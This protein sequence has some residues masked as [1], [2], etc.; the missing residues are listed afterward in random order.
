[1]KSKFLFSWSLVLALILS[2]TMSMK[3]YAATKEGE[4]YLTS[5]IP[6]SLSGEKWKFGYLEGDKFKDYQALLIAVIQGLVNLGWIKPEPQIQ[7]NELDTSEKLWHWL[8][9]QAK[10][11]YI[12]FV[13]DAYWSATAEDQ[14]Q[15]EK[16]NQA[17]L[18]RLEEQKNQ[19]TKELDLIIGMGDKAG[20][21]LATSRH[22]TNTVLMAISD[23][24][25][26]G[27]AKHNGQFTDKYKYIFTQVDLDFYKRQLEL[28]HDIFG[29]ETL[30]ITYQDDENGRKVAGVSTIEKTARQRGFKPIKR[31]IS[32]YQ[33]PDTRRGAIELLLTHHYLAPRIQ[34]MYLTINTALDNPK[35]LQLLLE[36][37]NKRKVYTFSQG[38]GD[39]VKYGVLMS[40]TATD[41]SF[42]GAFYA[43][44]IAKIINGATPN[45]LEQRYE[46]PTSIALNLEVARNLGWEIPVEVLTA[47]DEVYM[48]IACKIKKEDEKRKGKEDSENT[49]VKETDECGEPIDT[50]IEEEQK[51]LEE[52]EPAVEEEAVVD[53]TEPAIDKKPIVDEKSILKEKPVIEEK[54]KKPTV[55]PEK[56][57]VDQQLLEELKQI[58]QELVK[59]PIDE[60]TT[61][62]EKPLVDQQLHEK[63]K[64]INQELIEQPI[65]EKA[66]TEE[67]PV[68]AKKPVVYEKL[69]EYLKQ[70]DEELVELLKP[71]DKKAGT[72]E[73]PVV[74]EKPIVNEEFIEELKKI[75]ERLVELFKPIDEK[76]AT[77]E[78]PV[79]EKK[80]VVDE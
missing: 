4:L 69:I 46:T 31:T 1:M 18:K 70:I 25:E 79:V 49:I 66:T 43:E 26:I 74:V 33:N 64:Q 29:F 2:S 53:E 42:L 23:P 59:Q 17:V 72:E 13:A 6:K 32:S 65:D 37:L 56:P 61:T 54:E 52:E 35:N 62:E 44:K 21:V 38:T 11:K 76:A 30:G 57:L 71:I 58:D 41:Q 47:V 78:K 75:D 22:D 45:Q 77:E 8:A 48:E 9:T 67:K 40:I 63:L 20:K 36:P 12:E 5:P 39:Y 73:K 28:F 55:E 34:A 3:T 51:S 7:P 68:V 80:P 16:N 14:E 15:Q 10:S 60:K 50:K 27:I 24:V 19:E